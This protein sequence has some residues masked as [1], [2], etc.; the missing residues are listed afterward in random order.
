LHLHLQYFVTVRAVLYG[1]IWLLQDSAAP[2]H[3]AAEGGH[4]EVVRL[5]L[6]AGANAKDHDVYEGG[7]LVRRPPEQRIDVGKCGRGPRTVT[8]RALGPARGAGGKIGGGRYNSN[9]LECGP[10]LAFGDCS[11]GEVFRLALQSRC[12]GAH[13]ASRTNY[14]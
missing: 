3:L 10:M 14:G 4:K 7:T 1:D 2:L 13:W 11:H 6:D 12:F 8:G 5:L 9:I